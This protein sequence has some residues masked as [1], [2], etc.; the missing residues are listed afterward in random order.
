LAATPTAVIVSDDPNLCAVDLASGRLLWHDDRPRLTGTPAIA[1]NR[2]LLAAT[3]RPVVSALDV[4][5]GRLLWQARTGTDRV[6]H[7]GGGAFPALAVPGRD[8]VFVTDSAGVGAYDAGSGRRRWHAAIDGPR[9]GL[10]LDGGTVYV[11]D[12]S[13]ILHALRADT[14]TE[15]WARKVASGAQLPV[16]GGGGVLIAGAKPLSLDGATGRVRWTYGMP[17]LPGGLAVAESRVY[18]ATAGDGLYVLDSATAAELWHIPEPGQSRFIAGPSIT[19][20]VLYAADDHGVVHAYDVTTRRELWWW[21]AILL[22][23]EPSPG[24]PHPMTPRRQFAG[25]PVVLAGGTVLASDVSGVI[26]AIS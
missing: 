9:A 22:P 21:V 17:L 12:G 6:S 14:G 20:S 8:L 15:V 11:V 5:T 23:G 24:N 16:A 13:G 26:Y 10:A 7:A 18:A 4:R 3:D 2:V 19:G 1:D 25:D